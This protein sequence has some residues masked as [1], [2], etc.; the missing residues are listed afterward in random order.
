MEG[1]ILQVLGRWYKLQLHGEIPRLDGRPWRWLHRSTISTMQRPTHDI[2]PRPHYHVCPFVDWKCT[3]WTALN[4]R[5]SPNIVYPRR[6]W[7][8]CLH[9]LDIFSAN[10][11][12]RQLIDIRRHPF[13]GHNMDMTCN[14]FVVAI[15][16][17][18]IELWEI[19]PDSV[20]KYSLF[21]SNWLTP[22]PWK[23]ED[24]QRGRRGR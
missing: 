15:C 12:L 5:K 20:K 10:F 1:K 13:H 8:V 4:F 11:H 24:A 18:V 19:L 23:N 2:R 16:R 14:S 17:E 21:V 7:V 3:P 9:L 6:N 22:E